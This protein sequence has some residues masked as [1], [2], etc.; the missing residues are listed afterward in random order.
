MEQRL[1]SYPSTPT[2]IKVTV[3]YS[4]GTFGSGAAPKAQSS[5]INTLAI[6]FAQILV[7]YMQVIYILKGV[8]FRVPRVAGRM[9]DATAV[10]SDGVGAWVGATHARSRCGSGACRAMPCH[11]MPCNAMPCAESPPPPPQV[12]CIPLRS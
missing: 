7:T 5:R 11:A 10:V 8:T 1:H 6:H 4:F 12:V 2:S 9:L 3:G